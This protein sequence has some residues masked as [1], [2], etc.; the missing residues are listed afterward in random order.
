MTARSFSAVC[1]DAFRRNRVPAL[2][3]QGFAALV[4]ALY[5]A[6]PAVRPAFDVLAAAKQ[7]HGY[8]FSLTAGLIF[9]GLIPWMVVWRRNR[10]PDGQ[11]WRQLLFFATYWGCQGVIVDAFYRRQA[12]WFGE[13][14]TP[15]TLAVKVLVD[16]LPFNLLWGTPSAVILY[17]WKDRG[18]SFRDAFRDLR[19]SGWR[20]YASLQLSAWVI[21]I[22]AVTMIYSLPAPLQIPFFNLVLCFFTL[23]LTF[24]S[25]ETH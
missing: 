13:E 11:V 6:A 25:R 23:V 2:V 5:F 16:Q 10:I 3:L 17:T 20:R 15:R 19:H 12:V 24:V 8:L 9:G 1:R 7:R 22:P 21:W 4:L 18:F 14:L